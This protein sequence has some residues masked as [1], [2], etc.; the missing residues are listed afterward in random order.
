MV[1]FELYPLPKAK[2]IPSVAG[3]DEKT[4]VAAAAIPDNSTRLG[5]RVRNLDALLDRLVNEEDEANRKSSNDNKKDIDG[6]GNDDDDIWHGGVMVSRARVTE[7]GRVGVVRDADGRMIE[8]TDADYI[9]PNLAALATTPTP[10]T[11][12][13]PSS[14]TTAQSSNKMD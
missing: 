12:A 1:V 5:F 8:L 11:S 2:V 6:N 13:S 10:T 3:S 9:P 4:V 14:P 7:Y